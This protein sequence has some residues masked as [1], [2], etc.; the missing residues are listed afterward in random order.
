MSKLTEAEVP[1]FSPEFAER[2]R[3]HRSTHDRLCIDR[4]SLPAE[5]NHLKTAEVKKQDETHHTH[6]APDERLRAG[7]GSGH[8]P[9]QGRTYGGCKNGPKP[10][11]LSRRGGSWAGI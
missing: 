2:S 11:A 3:T 8:S 1:A 6:P 4:E 5:S 9:K 10:V 7:N